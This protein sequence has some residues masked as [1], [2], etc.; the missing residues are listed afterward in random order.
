MCMSV[1][2][3]CIH[4]FLPATFYPWASARS[5]SWPCQRHLQW[6][7]ISSNGVEFHQMANGS[8]LS[9]SSSLLTTTTQP[10]FQSRNDQSCTNAEPF[11]DS[12]RDVRPEAGLWLG[13]QGW[14]PRLYVQVI[15]SNHRNQILQV[16]AL[17]SPKDQK[18]LKQA[19]MIL[20]CQWSR[21][22]SVLITSVGS[23]QVKCFKV[24]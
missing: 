2:T 18:N 13:R 8:T 15:I 3:I 11:P 23:A 12:F 20:G 6:D 14:H 10:D 21:A 24:N 17:M 7:R 19:E 5:L 22:V 4:N 16:L 1:D 9:L